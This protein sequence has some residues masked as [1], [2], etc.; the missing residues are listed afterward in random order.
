MSDQSGSDP[1][2]LQAL[3][4]AALQDY[5]RQ[6]GIVLAKHSLA[7]KLQNCHSVESLT[8]V[9][10]EQT[11]DFSEFRRRDKVLKPLKTTL[12]VLDKLSAK[13]DAIGMV[14]DARGIIGCLTIL[15]SIL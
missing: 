11:Q 5:E 12:S 15:T 6:T 13:A 2:R 9:F 1:S 8:A 14:C 10:K 4:E 7:E 3:L